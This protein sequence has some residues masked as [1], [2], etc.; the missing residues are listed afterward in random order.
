MLAIVVTTRFLYSHAILGELNTTLSTPQFNANT[1]CYK[2]ILY[3]FIIK[4]YSNHHSL[5]H[6]L[7]V[8]QTAVAGSGQ[9]TL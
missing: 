3:L 4:L 9:S 7:T 6:S 8:G 1:P 2:T 5:T